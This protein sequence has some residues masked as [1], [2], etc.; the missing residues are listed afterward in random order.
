MWDE[1]YD[2][3]LPQASE[4]MLKIVDPMKNNSLIGET[5]ITPTASNLKDISDGGSEWLNFKQYTK[6]RKQSM[7]YNMLHFVEI[8]TTDILEK[9]IM[10][11]YEVITT[12]SY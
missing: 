6:V 8:K 3:N 2:V 9:S 5:T 11:S 1:G 10:D 4:K 7:I 12:S